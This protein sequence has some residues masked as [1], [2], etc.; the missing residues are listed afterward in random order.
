M[1]V[2]T[3]PFTE[4]PLTWATLRQCEEMRVSPTTAAWN[5]AWIRH[6]LQHLDLS[7][8]ILLDLGSGAA[9]PF[10]FWYAS[11]VRHAFL[12]DLYHPPEKFQKS[13]SLIHDLEQA[14][15]LPDESTDL[16]I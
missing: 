3:H 12:I 7:E 9:S 14:L 4:P 16:V 6:Q 1:P 2:P 13:T 15:P 10:S 8:S 11:R 5:R